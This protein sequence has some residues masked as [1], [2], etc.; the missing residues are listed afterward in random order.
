MASKG[1]LFEILDLVAAGRLRP[2]VHQVMPLDEI[3]AAHRLLESREAFGK[4]V[5]VS[6]AV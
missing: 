1:R 3:A 5:L 6:G 4:L 2:V